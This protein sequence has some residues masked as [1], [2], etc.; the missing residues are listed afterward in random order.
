MAR[1]YIIVSLAKGQNK[2]ANFARKI[3]RDVDAFDIDGSLLIIIGVYLEVL[4]N[5]SFREVTG[6]V[7]HCSEFALLTVLGKGFTG[8]I[9]QEMVLVRQK[10]DI[11]MFGIAHGMG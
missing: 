11:Y 5:N 3:G 1:E 8:S 2:V 7:K 9:F 10:S 4:F 6:A